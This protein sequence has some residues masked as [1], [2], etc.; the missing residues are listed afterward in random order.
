[1]TTW[2]QNYFS[3]NKGDYRKVANV[4]VCVRIAG[5]GDVPPPTQSAIALA[6]LYLKGVKRWLPHCLLLTTPVVL[7]AW[8]WS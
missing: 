4:H 6:Y 8:V 3:S 5:N 1:M 2:E 7:H